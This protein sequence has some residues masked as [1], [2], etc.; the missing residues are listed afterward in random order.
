MT[1]EKLSDVLVWLGLAIVFGSFIPEIIS[2]SPVAEGSKSL[3]MFA[4]VFC[5]VLNRV[6][7]GRFRLLPWLSK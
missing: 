4:F 3:W 5:V 2:G 6:I 7:I 1:K